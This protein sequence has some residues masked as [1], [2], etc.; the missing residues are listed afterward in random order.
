MTSS[1]EEGE[2]FNN[3][4]MQIQRSVLE[5]AASLAEEIHELH[6]E[7]LSADMVKKMQSAKMAA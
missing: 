5:L 1:S 6:E 2:G 7:I 4:N 3:C